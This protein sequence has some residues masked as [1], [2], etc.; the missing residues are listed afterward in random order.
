MNE[1]FVEKYFWGRYIR[2]KYQIFEELVKQLFWPTSTTMT[3]FRL[4]KKH[5][6]LI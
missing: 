2:E 1:K 6:D 5:F 3:T 4:Y